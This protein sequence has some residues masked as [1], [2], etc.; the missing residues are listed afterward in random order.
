MKDEKSVGADNAQIMHSIGQ[1][2]GAV[3]AMHTG[4]TARIEDIRADVRRMEAAQGER[5]D[6][7]EDS[8]GKRIDTLEGSVGKRIDSLGSRVTALE[9]EDKRQIEKTAK[10]SAMGGGIG[11]ALATV[12]VELIKRA[13]GG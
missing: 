12:A 1:L 9:N 13:A 3:Q 5:M 8:L 7:I 11:G 10:L 6:R 2:T 4:L